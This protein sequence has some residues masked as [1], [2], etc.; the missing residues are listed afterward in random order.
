MCLFCFRRTCTLTP[1]R[2]QHRKTAGQAASSDSTGAWEDLLLNGIFSFSVT[3]TENSP[4]LDG[5]WENTNYMESDTQVYLWF[6]TFPLS[7]A[8]CFN[9]RGWLSWEGE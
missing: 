2:R 3:E 1:G 9:T 7:V 6:S 8:E 4:T 5:L